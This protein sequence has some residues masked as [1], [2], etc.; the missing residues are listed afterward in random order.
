VAYDTAVQSPVGT[1]NRGPYSST[2]AQI[3]ASRATKSEGAAGGTGNVML[4]VLH[5]RSCGLTAALYDGRA[6]ISI[7]AF[8]SYLE[9]P[10][11]LLYPHKRFYCI[12]QAQY[13][14]SP[15]YITSAVNRC[16]FV[17]QDS[18][19]HSSEYITEVLR[20]VFGI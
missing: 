16:V 4:T 7:L 14:Y 1:T 17:C 13:D 19:R 20:L 11:L 9:Q 15:Q 3:P 5:T 8:H 6:E 2:V 18:S 12:E 10:T